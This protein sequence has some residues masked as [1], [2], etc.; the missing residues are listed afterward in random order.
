MKFKMLHSV[1]ESDFDCLFWMLQPDGISKEASKNFLPFIDGVTRGPPILGAH[2]G[3]GGAEHA[4]SNTRHVEVEKERGNML[5]G[6]RHILTTATM[7]PTV[8]FPTICLRPG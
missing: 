7:H 6:G 4:F 2:A 1:D 8:S 3:M 5:T